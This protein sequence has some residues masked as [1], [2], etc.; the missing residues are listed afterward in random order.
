MSRTPDCAVRAS[1]N[2]IPW[3]SRA[4]EDLQI[5]SGAEN[6]FLI[7][8]SIIRP[9]AVGIDAGGSLWPI[10]GRSEHWAFDLCIN[11]SLFKYHVYATCLLLDNLDKGSRNWVNSSE[12]FALASDSGLFCNQF[13]RSLSNLLKAGWKPVLGLPW[14]LYS[15]GLAWTLRAEVVK[16]DSSAPE[17]EL[18]LFSVETLRE[19]W[20]IFQTPDCFMLDIA[21]LSNDLEFSLWDRTL[22]LSFYHILLKSYPNLAKD[23]A[24]LFY[25]LWYNHL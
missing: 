9:P 12:K 1:E 10:Q 23:C 25:A 18:F 22:Q 19:L 15:V 11:K 20:H 21:W 16:E 3:Q 2:R 4:R 8:L 6:P 17:F 13:L 5:P 24:T 14:S 7:P